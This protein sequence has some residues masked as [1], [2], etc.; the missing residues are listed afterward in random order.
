MGLS[1]STVEALYNFAYLVFFTQKCSKC[2]KSDEKSKKKKIALKEQ[3]PTLWFCDMKSS[4]K[5]V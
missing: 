2:E 4:K 3:I 5:R 1:N